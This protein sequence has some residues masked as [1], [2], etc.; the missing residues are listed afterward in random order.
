[1]LRLQRRFWIC[2]SD[3]EELVLEDTMLS[4]NMGHG[5]KGGLGGSSDSIDAV[6]F[7][8]KQAAPAD[9][10][11][12]RN[13]RCDFECRSEGRLVTLRLQDALE[14]GSMRCIRCK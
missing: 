5:W 11:S 8:G 1:V 13:V 12:S 2:A 6:A 7:T 4:Q 9:L 3:G 14:R 10:L